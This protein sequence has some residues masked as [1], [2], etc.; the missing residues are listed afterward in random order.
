MKKLQ[1]CITLLLMSALLLAACKS[2]SAANSS[3]ESLSAGLSPEN[4][5]TGEKNLSGGILNLQLSAEVQSLDPHATSD[6]ISFTIIRA[7]S[8]GLYILGDKGV[9]ETA[10]AESVEKSS[11][12]LTYTFKIRDN[13]NWTS[14]APVTAQDFVFAWREL[15]NPENAFEYANIPVSAGIVNAKSIAAG[16]KRPEELGVTALNDKTLE[17]KLERPLA[18]LESLLAMPAMLPINEDFYRAQG[19]RYGTS[20]ETTNANGPFQLKSYQPSAMT[21]ELER[22]PGYYAADRIQL[23]GLKYQVIKDNQQ[24]LLSYQNGDLDVVSLSGDQA[25]FFLDDPEFHPVLTGFLWFLSPNT[26]VAGLE[27][28]NLRRAIALSYDKDSLAKNILKDGSV[29]ADYYIT[30][31]TAVGPDGKDFRETTGTFLKTDKVLA[32]E[33][34]NKAKEELGVSSL[35]YKVLVE[36]AESAI[37]V[38]QYIQAQVAET[39]PGLTLNIEQMPKKNRVER[40]TAKDYE[41]GFTR[42]GPDYPDPTTYL[43]LWATGSAYNYGSWENSEYDALLA[44]CESGD[45]SGDFSARWEALKKAEKIAADDA[46]VLPV[47][48]KAEAVLIKP[49]IKGYG[50]TQTGGHIPWYAEK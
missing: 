8:D 19:D 34:W 31:L 2:P 49:N 38:V 11:D 15:I 9:P 27:N 41:I 43:D 16:D 21:I 23:D 1:V 22:N 4:S 32:L 18:Y 10:I 46:A 6:G 36:D 42:W 17:V 25:E 44:A 45:L 40:M 33:Y 12:N 37:N 14:G 39:L 50:F 5:G 48:Q 20:P 7:F 24:A 30:K 28:A 35:S 26:K 47:Y 29:P 13:A 3:G